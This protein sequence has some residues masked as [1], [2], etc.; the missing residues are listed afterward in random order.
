MLDAGVPAADRLATTR[1]VEK[2]LRDLVEVG[3]D[4]DKAT[5]FANLAVGVIVAALRLEPIEAG[6]RRKQ[7]IVG[8]ER[9]SIEVGVQRG[10]KT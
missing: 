10:D 8:V 7:V 1:Q 9:R 2:L 4:L 6:V 5:A 3:D